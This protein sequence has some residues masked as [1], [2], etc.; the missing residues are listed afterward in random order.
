MTQLT[1]QLLGHP[2]LMRDGAPAPPPRGKKVWALLAYLIRSEA[3]VSRGR[4][5]SLLF[6]D[7]DDPLGTLRWNLAELRRLFGIRSILR[8][9]PLELHLPTDTQVDLE[10]VIHGTWRQAMS[11]P[12]IGDAFLEGLNFPTCPAFETWLLTERRH[13]ANAS[14]HVMR[15]A[16]LGG[17]AAGAPADAVKLARKLIEVDPLDESY[18][19]LLIRSLAASGDRTGASSQ[20]KACRALLM[21]ELGVKP[22]PDVRNAVDTPTA[23]PPRR[24]VAGS[25]SAR[26]QMD[27]GEAAIAAGAVDAGLA[28]LRSA[29]AE[30]ETVGN[31]SLEAQA[32]LALGSSLIHAPRGRDEEGS[33]VLHRAIEIASEAGLDR[34]VAGSRRELGY[35]EMLA[36]RYDRGRTWLEHALEAVGD[37][38]GE[39]AMIRAVLGGC[40]SDTAHYP[41]AITELERSLALAEEVGAGKQIAF[42]CAFLAR[43]WFLTGDV[44]EAR[45]SGLRAKLMAEQEGWTSF[46]AWPESFVGD[47]FLAEGDLEGAADAYEH[48]F[49][50]GCQIGDPCWEGVGARG[51]GLVKERRGLVDE[52]IDWLDDARTRCVRIAD[53]YMWIE[54]YCQDTLCQV[55]IAHGVEGAPQFVEE[56]EAGAASR[57]MREFVARAHIHRYRLGDE[58]ALDAATVLAANIANPSL[59]EALDEARAPAASLP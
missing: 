14:A 18:Q 53:A 10:R 27:A 9:E 43:V 38:V 40:W 12:T 52:A 57:G 29:A 2:S 39:E 21:K 8:G 34:V 22:G 20:L 51:I 30:A 50:L 56:L 7:A 6:A 49:T 5:A 59:H 19:A 17:I 47:C 41:E 36:A 32:L 4:L 3:P 1:I 58:K 23:S 15:E 46:V 48:A 42:T 13:F 45:T 31:A 28:S 54:S 24:A 25:A 44:D 35:V 11:V 16:A 33:V 26:A 37:D 55:A